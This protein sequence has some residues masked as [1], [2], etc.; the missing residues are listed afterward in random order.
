MPKPTNEL[1]FPV[2]FLWGSA[3]AAHQVEG[4]NYNSDWWQWE[5]SDRRA[6]QLRKQN[7]KPEDYYSAEA[8]DSYNRY[9]ED[10]D[11]LV[12]LNQNAHRISVEWARIEPE[13]GR[14]DANEIGHYRK[15]LQALKRRGIKTF[16]TLHHFTNPVWFAELGGWEKNDNTSVFVKYASRVLAELGQWI[17]FV[18]IINEPNVYA[19]QSYVGGLWVPQR[20][21]IFLAK[22]VELNMLDAHKRTYLSLKRL[23]PN[24]Q[25]G[26]AHH[27]YKLDLQGVLKIFNGLADQFWYKR[28]L[29]TQ[30]KYSDFIGINYYTRQRMG[31]TSKRP[32]ISKLP[33]IFK[34]TDFGWEIYPEGLYQLLLQFKKYSKPVY[35]TENGLADSRDVMR[36]DFIIGHLEAIHR[37]IQE[38][39]D[40]RGYL[41]W[42]L[43]DN[44]E[45]A[46]A[47][48]KEFGLVHIDRRNNFKREVRP[49]ARIYAEIC[50][51]N[52][53]TAAS[54][55][56]VTHK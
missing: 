35:I 22:T 27:V 55:E 50:K 38:G 21:N 20:R 12:E 23:F 10:F 11:L 5:H 26:S 47:Y 15:V 36:K 1:E 14:F 3:T 49:S 25:F 6:E 45:W 29:D 51:T 34:E 43:L 46:E 2:G 53:I 4:N 39:V 8:C 56:R 40:V 30:A 28:A 33:A 44:F 52:K 7:K 13:Q 24:I 32:Y 41:H 17:D 31:L 42:S 48:T 19:G 37:A 54:E 18:C 9:E 16:V